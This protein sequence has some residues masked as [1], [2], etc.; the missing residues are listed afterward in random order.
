VKS[1]QFSRYPRDFNI[2]NVHMMF[3]HV[4][5]FPTRL[6]CP[7]STCRRTSLRWIRTRCPSLRWICRP[8]L[9]W[10]CCPSLRWNRCS[11]CCLHL[12][13]P[14]SKGRRCP[15]STC[16]W[17]SLRWIR[18]RCPSLRRICR[19]SLRRTCCPSLRPRW[20]RLLICSQS[21]ISHSIPSAF[22]KRSEQFEN[23]INLFIV[24]KNKILN[25]KPELCFVYISLVEQLLCFPIYITLI[26]K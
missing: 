19:S 2:L 11:S 26:S 25:L 1:L 4:V 16:R 23:E 21:Q 24:S 5:C 6:R 22:D 7:S 17:T 8:S 15:S 18:T 10:I 20:T 14:S 13:C 12:R 9:R 3:T